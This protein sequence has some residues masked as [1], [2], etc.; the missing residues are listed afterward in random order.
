MEWA[1]RTPDLPAGRISRAL[2][3]LRLYGVLMGASLR[4]EGQ[5]RANLFTAMLGAIAHQTAGFAFVWIIIDKFGALGGW[6]LPEIAFLYG[7]RL[8]AHGLFTFFGSQII[9]PF[10]EIVREG[11]FDRFLVRPLD[12]FVQ[13]LT[14]R[15]TLL[16]FGDLAGGTALLTVGTV[17]V[18]V[19]WSPTAVAY[20]ILALAGGAMVEGAVQL[21]IAGLSFRLLSTQS[22]RWGM[23]ELFTTFGGYPLKIFPTA[24]NYGLT[25]VIPLAFLAYLPATLLLGRTDELAV[26]PLIAY[27]APLAGV[28]LICGAHRFWHHQIRYYTSSGH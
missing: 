22:L 5:Y 7:M 17:H 16:V 10:D 1:P 18:D 28:L 3:T 11:E 15:T 12:P 21:A 4:A 20:L 14:R 24:V 26:N 2:R 23:D 19:D 27:V 6:S 25:F 8:T 13:L 9:G